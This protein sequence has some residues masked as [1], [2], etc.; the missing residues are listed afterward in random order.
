MTTSGGRK[1]IVWISALGVVILVAGGLAL[2]MLLSEVPSESNQTRWLS[3]SLSGQMNG[4]P[5]E[6]EFYLDPLDSPLRAVDLVEILNYAAEDSSI[7]GLLIE[8]DGPVLSMAMAWEIREELLSFRASG[9]ECLVGSRYYGNVELYLASACS[10]LA[11][12]PA[13]S[14]SVYG[15]RLATEYYAGLLEMIG[16]TPDIERIGAY[17]S[18][19]EQ[20][21][22]TAPSEPTVEMLDSLLNDINGQFISAIAEG[23]GVAETNVMDWLAQPPVTADE[24]VEAK[25]V[26]LSAPF[27][28]LEEGI[29]EP[30]IT[31]MD[32]RLE[33]GQSRNQNERVA[34]LHIQGAIVDGY[35]TT[36]LD[37]SAVSGDVTISQYLVD[38][39]EDDSVNAVV[40]RVDSPGGSA[41]A[42]HVMADGISELADKKPV[43]VSMGSYAASG[44]YYVSAPASVIFASPTTLTGSIGVFGGKMS[45]GGLLDRA[46]ITT[47]ETTRSPF[48][49]IYEPY[50]PFSDSER[51]LIQ[52]QMQATYD[53]FLTVVSDGRTLT[54]EEVDSIGQGRVWSGLQASKNGLV[55]EIGGLERAIRHASELAGLSNPSRVT[56]P[57]QGTFWDALLNG[58]GASPLLGAEQITATQ[59]VADVAADI[60]DSLVLAETLNSGGIAAVMPLRITVD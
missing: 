11:L 21:Q 7:N 30:I 44:G 38:L 12:H 17:K 53:R 54:T 37:G 51:E 50:R 57:R 40:I 47:W 34:I 10:T 6:G 1:I 36:N 58:A 19:P 24:A 60:A 3:L 2:G 16:V 59:L 13:G 15:L 18:A 27:T 46:G 9:R 45:L 52:R 43:V 28:Q 39:L 23:R 42:S 48:A 32:Y 41:L 26:D 56:I 14:P 25:M 35:S 4:G 8:L 49:S 20:Y 22:E 55:D 33:I 29:E 5:T 31:G